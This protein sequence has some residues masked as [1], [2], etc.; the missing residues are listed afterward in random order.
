MSIDEIYF[1]YMEYHAS[2]DEFLSR[3]Q[4]ARLINKCFLEKNRGKSSTSHA[5]DYPNITWNTVPESQ[6]TIL[7]LAQVAALLQS[8]HG[9][10][11]TKLADTHLR[12]SKPSGYLVNGIPVTK[13]IYISQHGRWKCSVGSKIL[14]YI[15]LHMPSEVTLKTDNISGIAAAVDAVSLCQ[16]KPSEGSITLGS[17]FYLEY[18]ST[19]TQ[20]K[21]TVRRVRIAPCK[22]VIPLVGLAKTCA[23]CTDLRIMVRIINNFSL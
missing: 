11:V 13:D 15:D 16:G 21:E 2:E 1:R 17:N 10:I 22:R 12:A 14:R 7:T 5:T 4:L 6:K 3:N 19:E 20:P 23:R 9:F 8:R 18:W